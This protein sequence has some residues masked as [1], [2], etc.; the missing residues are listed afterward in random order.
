[1]TAQVPGPS[2][3]SPADSS[4]TWVMCS[5][6]SPEM[7]LRLHSQHPQS[8]PQSFS[9]PP[10]PQF[11][12]HT[13]TNPFVPPRSTLTSSLQQHHSPQ[14]SGKLKT[15]WRVDFTRSSSTPFSLHLPACSFPSL[16]P[17]C[18]PTEAPQC[19]TTSF[20]YLTQRP[21][22]WAQ[23]TAEKLS[24]NPLHQLLNTPL[25]FALQFI[26]L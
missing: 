10:V 13:V 19:E 9:P 25:D 16:L 26:T 23:Y 2:A 5:D 6:F 11:L 12:P 17:S 14:A 21:A 24:A 22:V 7:I 4:T 15:S 1:M 8:S 18:S 20:H 3:S